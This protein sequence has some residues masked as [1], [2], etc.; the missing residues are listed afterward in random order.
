MRN[1]LASC[2]KFKCK[3]VFVQTNPYIYSDTEVGNMTE[4]SATE[5]SSMKGKVCKEV[6]DL[7]TNEIKAGRVNAMIM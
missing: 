2:G 7:V 3:L 6:C 4:E 5:P 1:V